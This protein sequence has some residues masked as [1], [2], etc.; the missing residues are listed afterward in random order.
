MAHPDED[1]IDLRQRVLNRLYDL[2]NPL[3]TGS[4]SGW[5]FGQALRTS[6]LY[7]AA[8]AEPGVSYVDNIQ[9][10][11]EDV[12]ED[13]IHCLAVDAFQPNT[14]YAGSH[15]TVYRSMNDGDG[16]AAVCQFPDQ[17]VDSIQ[18]H[19]AV[20]GVIAVATHNSQNAGSHIHVSFD[21]GEKWQQK[22]VTGFEISDMAWVTR[23]GSSSLFFA[24]SV[25]IFELSMLPDAALVQVFVRPD[26]EK[27]GYYAIT[28]THLK[29][30]VTV[31]VASR[32]MGGIF[33]SDKGGESQS[34]RNIGKA[35]EDVRVLGVQTS[36]DRSFL[37]AGLAAP[38]A[39]DPGKGCFAWEILGN[40]Q[41]PPEDWQSFTDQWLGGSC[42][43]VAF[44]QDRILAATFDGGVLWLEKHGT[45]EAWHAPDINC[46]LPQAT[47][48][49]PFDRVDALAADRLRSILMAGGKSGIF[50]SSDGGEHYEYSSRKTFSDR[51]TLPPNWL[52]CSGEHEIEVVNQYE[53]S[54][55]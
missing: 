10:I 32:S 46:G 5:R 18:T 36:G 26:D 25:G 1:P 31:A 43:E 27:I 38:I 15:S 54:S 49:H 52:F 11:V 50:R 19:N 39:G 23:D 24:T 48:E 42:V 44:Q 33:L 2:I 22:A 45:G 6:H 30:G 21:C 35:G 55:D 9:L 40:G 12:P 37:W 20:P 13:D 53:D 51:V 34:F 47:R 8:L 28:A 3:P 17:I 4:H 29:T 41:D 7:D 14:W 16:W